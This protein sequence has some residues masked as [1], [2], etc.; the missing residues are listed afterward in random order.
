MMND[1]RMKRKNIW[2]DEWF[3]FDNFEEEFERMRALMDRFMEDSISGNVEGTRG[4]FVYGLNLRQGPDGRVHMERF[5]NTGVESQPVRGDS[6]QSG[7]CLAASLSREPL[8][9]VIACDDKV[10]ITVEVP[11]VKK[12]DID[13]EVKDGNL[14]IKVDSGNRRYYKE[15]E[16]PCKVDP[17]T[18]QATHNNG[19][20][21]ITFKRIEGEVK[22]KRID[23]E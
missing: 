3:G 21:D 10:F 5:G 1:D 9:D 20:L 2:D 15:I 16:L 19:V 22:T 23:I 8:T 18:S 11:G 4:P 13:L 12:R 14:T 6:C 7:E 17:D